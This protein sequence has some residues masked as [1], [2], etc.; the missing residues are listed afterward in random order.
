MH[1]DA[2]VINGHYWWFRIS[3]RTWIDISILLSLSS[4][5]QC[6]KPLLVHDYSGLCYP[7]YTGDYNNPTCAYGS[8]HKW[9]TPTAGWFISW[10]ILL[11]WED[12]SWVALFQETSISATGKITR[13]ISG[14]KQ[15]GPADLMVKAVQQLCGLV[16]QLVMTNIAMENHHC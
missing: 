16:Y 8:F 6:S 12:V 4:F 14:S 5:E 13:I 11:Q 9:G 15:I 10:K 2:M 7:I 1:G 3:M